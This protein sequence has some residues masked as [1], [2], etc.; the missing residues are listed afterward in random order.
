MENNSRLPVRIVT[1]I[2]LFFMT[3]I[4]GGLTFDKLVGRIPA[5]TV[6]VEE[7][8][9]EKEWVDPCTRK[10]EYYRPMEIDFAR[11]VIKII[12]NMGISPDPEDPQIYLGEISEK[13]RNIGR[14]YYNFLNGDYENTYECL[15]DVLRHNKTTLREELVRLGIILVNE[16]GKVIYGE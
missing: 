10:Q 7:G 2:C 8:P 16:E 1:A 14:F 11:K 15:V 3:Y 9:K 13:H 12:V 5:E 6:A 4:I